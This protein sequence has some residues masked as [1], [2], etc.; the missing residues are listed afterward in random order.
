MESKLTLKGK[1]GTILIDA[2]AGG[3]WMGGGDKNSIALV[4]S[5]SGPC[6]GIYGP[7]GN[8]DFCCDIAIGVNENDEGFVTSRDAN[9]EVK[10][11]PF[12]RLI[13]ML[14]DLESPVPS[15]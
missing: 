10:S 9:G 12:S 7:K 6:I 13:N 11:I 3:I 1:A 2:D 4:L 8:P 15:T 5:E 14:S